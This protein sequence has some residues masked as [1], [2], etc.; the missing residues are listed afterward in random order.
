M[1]EWKHLMHAP[2]N[3]IVKTL[4]VLLFAVS[5]RAQV[6]NPQALLD[7]ARLNIAATVERAPRYTCMEDI[8]RY[9]YANRKPVRPGCDTDRPPE[10]SDRNLVRSDRL[11]LD[12]AVG[13]G[14]EIFSWHG[15]KTFQTEEID[16]LVTAGPVSSGM[17]F[18]FLSSVFLEGSAQID[19]QGFRTQAGKQVAVFGYS[20]PR[21]VSKFETRTASGKEVMGYHGEFTLD[22]AT[23]ELEELRVLTDDMPKSAW[24]CSFD[25]TA[26][27]GVTLFHG[28]GFQLPVNVVMNILD[29][30]HQLTRTVTQYRDCHEFLGESVL[31]FDGSA[32]A[33]TPSLPKAVRT[34]SSGLPVRIR[35][36]SRVNPETAWAGDRIEGKLAA[37][38]FDEHGMA[39]LPKGTGVVGRLLRLETWVRPAHSYTVALQFEELSLAGEDYRLNLKSVMEP[40]A[41]NNG[42]DSIRRR[43]QLENPPIGDD[44][45]ACR[46][47]LTDTGVSLQG[48]VTYWVTR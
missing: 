16:R 46:F 23:R 18:S 31:H 6:I 28:A 30:N 11:R 19:F 37:D 15:Q 36:T 35:I 45:A 48:V 20:V 2:T 9:W 24:V 12:V 25:S 41:T 29:V 22:V 14:Q 40:D 32:P 34:L 17:Y 4:P 39:L 8:E 43:I 47:R 42:Q 10:I 3:G 38:V 26:R 1:M 33:R 21:D 13:S 7:E 5:L 44:P 27:Y